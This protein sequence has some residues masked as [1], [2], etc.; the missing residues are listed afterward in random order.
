M[1]QFYR[2]LVQEQII[3]SL[4]SVHVKKMIGVIEE[5][6]FFIFQAFATIESLA[7]GGVKMGLP[8]DM[9]TKLAAQTLFVS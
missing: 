7:D 2:I 9:A 6:F 5:F 8:R 1:T 4:V 3:A